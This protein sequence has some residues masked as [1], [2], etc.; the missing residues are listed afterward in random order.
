MGIKNRVIKKVKRNSPLYK[1]LRKVYRILRLPVTIIKKKRSYTKSYSVKELIMQ[2]NGEDGYRRLDIFVRLLAIENEYGLND[3]GWDLYRKMQRARKEESEEE[4]ELRVSDFRKLMKSWDEN[5]YNPKSKILLFNNLELDNGSH[6]LAMAIFHG[7]KTINCVVSRKAGSIDYGVK[8]FEAH[9]FAQDEIQHIL[10]KVTDVTSKMSIEISCILW[11]PVYEYYDEITGLIG[12]KYWI[13]GYRD[14]ELSEETFVRFIKGVY[15]IDDI[16]DWKIEAKIQHMKDA[17]PKVVRVLTVTFDHPTFRCK[18]A[19]R[20]TI[21]VQGEELKKMVRDT[22]K[23]KLDNYFYDIIC[24]TGDNS[25]HSEYIRKLCEPNFTLRKYF[26]YMEGRRPKGLEETSIKSA[27]SVPADDSK[28]MIVKLD[29][30]YTPKNFPDTFAFSKDVD[31]ICSRA[32]IKQFVSDTTAYF[33]K[34]CEGYYDP[35][36]VI[37]LSESHTK[38]RVELNGFLIIQIDISCE[39]EGMK[40]GYVEKS[41]DRRESRDNYYVASMADEICYR[42]Y[43]YKIYPEKVRHLE[44]V[45]AHEKEIERGVL[46]ESGMEW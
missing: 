26:D 23:E 25:V 29:S 24:H 34:V 42:L 28:W 1:V 32:S 20:N 19:N 45:K 15:K 7:E 35:V 22:Y 44:Y 39:L 36:K 37:N 18:D 21:L 9:D 41:L 3:Y 27:G 11:P 10:D 4:I 14:V 8:W 46:K 31:I 5:G 33:E 38:V 43:E 16:A 2:Q 12:E 13:K 17:Y 30:E 6:R 40:A